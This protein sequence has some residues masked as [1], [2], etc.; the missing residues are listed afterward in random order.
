MLFQFVEKYIQ[1]DDI[2]IS[3]KLITI[4]TLTAFVLYMRYELDLQQWVIT[5]LHKYILTKYIH[6]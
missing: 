3:Y 6:K 5:I 4:R 2:K 1:N